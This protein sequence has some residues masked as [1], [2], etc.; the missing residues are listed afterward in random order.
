[1]SERFPVSRTAI[2]SYC[3]CKF[4]TILIIPKVFLQNYRL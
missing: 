4:K 1:L 2:I 3:G